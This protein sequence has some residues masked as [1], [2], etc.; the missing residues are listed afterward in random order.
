MVCL[1]S[2]GPNSEK[3]LR[4]ASRL[5]GRLNRNWYAVYVQTP[6]EEPTVIDAHTQRILSGTLTLAKQLGATVFT[7]KGEDITDTILRFAREYRV[8]TIVVGTPTPKPFWK[9]LWRKTTVERLIHEAKGF[10]VVVLDT[11]KEEPLEIQAPQEPARPV[12]PEPPLPVSPAAPPLCDFLAPE[13]VVIWDGPVEKEV[14][15]RTLAEAAVAGAEVQPAVVL[16]DIAKRE[17]QGSTFLNEGVAL[18][19]A[20]IEGLHHPVVALGLTRK[21][22]SD[23]STEKP[24]ESVFLILSP[25]EAPEI[26]IQILG[27][28]SRASRNRELVRNLGICRTPAEVISAFRDWETSMRGSPRAAEIKR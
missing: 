4:Y 13:R 28:V 3:L 11:R 2:R 5:A 23:V 18:P 9:T 16:A 27:Q 25:E 19:H 8:G 6:S 17:G 12:V 24:I 21:G 7:Y 10:N 26:Q 22:V 20:R 14:V 15:L 1:S